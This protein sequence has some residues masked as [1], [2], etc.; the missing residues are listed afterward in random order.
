MPLIKADMNTG[1]PRPF[2]SVKFSPIGRTYSFLLPELALDGEPGP[3]TAPPPCLVPGDSVI[4]QTSEGRALGTVARS[5][6]ALAA[7]KLPPPDSDVRVV[8][9]ATR[10]DIVLRLQHQQ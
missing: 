1:Q 3:A 8:R 10:E 5:V 9:R 7:R 6:P 2:V 4:V